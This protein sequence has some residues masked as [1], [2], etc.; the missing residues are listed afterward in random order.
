[1]K[2][3]LALVICIL[4]CLGIFTGCDAVAKLWLE[5]A[6]ALRSLPYTMD[7]A[8]IDEFYDLL[9]QAESLSI[10]G[11]DMDA[12]DAAVEKLDDAYMALIDQN[13]I[14]YIRYCLDQTK[15]AESD[16]YLYTTDVVA[17]AESA[18]Y[19]ML[20]RVYEQTPVRDEL[21]EDWTQEEIDRL[22]KYDDRVAQLEK[23]NTELLLQFRE[24]DEQ[25]G[26][27]AMIPLYNE[28]VTNNNAVAQIFGYEH[29]YDY[30]YAQV[31]SRDYGQQELTQ[32]RRYISEYL[33]PAY[34]QAD[35]AF[36]GV[37]AQLDE[38][39]ETMLYALLYDPYDAGK[40]DY[41]RSYMLDM[42]ETARQGMAHM[43]EQDRAVFTAYRHAYQGAF[44]T[45][46]GAEPFCYFGTGYNDSTTIIHEL[47][48]YY[49][50]LYVEPWTQPMDLSETQS[51]GNEW[52]FT[53]WLRKQLSPSLYEVFSEYKLRTDMASVI[54]Y[55]LI[56]SFE[57]QVYSHENAGNLTLEEYDGIMAQI[58]QDYGGIEYIQE[59]LFDIQT[60][61]KRI[62]IESPVYYISYAVSAVAAIDLFLTAQ[63]DEAQARQQYCVLMEEP[64]EDG[65][66]LANIRKAGIA[67]PFEETVYQKLYTRCVN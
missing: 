40:I 53:A 13:Q 27:E 56:D 12:I 41:V 26:D 57:Q 30:A 15:K 8:M 7:Q 64:V 33:L 23:R 1:M 51:Q 35:E 4:L 17:E 55:T 5:D 37:Y 54:A 32:M 60:Y 63:E 10:A 44:T 36:D 39:E 67:G 24:L 59:N 9:E 21:F 47:G 22:L 61:W 42:P 29:F 58:A 50:S 28:F 19:A 6:E 48:H 49:G 45:W 62:V 43:F 2:R 46:I 38:Q 3:I 52:L 14:A 25:A 31:Y 66:F 34:A 16:R 65:G 18:Y 20:K 11:E